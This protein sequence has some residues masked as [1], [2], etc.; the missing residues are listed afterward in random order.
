MR[1]GTRLKRKGNVAN[2]LDIV[3]VSLFAQYIME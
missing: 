1:A 2:S 3:P